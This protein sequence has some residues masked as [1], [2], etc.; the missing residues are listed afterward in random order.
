[1]LMFECGSS[2]DVALAVQWIFNHCNSGG[3][4]R[5]K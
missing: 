5:G 2:S 4:V 3:Q 1:M